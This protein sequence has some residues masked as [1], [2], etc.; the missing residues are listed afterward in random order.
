M[1]A[2]ALSAPAPPVLALE[3]V[4]KSFAVGDGDRPFARA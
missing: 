3:G 2:A 1:S 4:R